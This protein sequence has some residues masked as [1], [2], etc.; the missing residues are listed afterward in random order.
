[1]KNL[2]KILPWIVC[3]A[4]SVLLFL[5]KQDQ[6][7]SRKIYQAE[8]SIS[9]LVSVR[10]KAEIIHAKFIE[11]IEVLQTRRIEH[12]YP[13]TLKR[14][15]ALKYTKEPL[16]PEQTA[17]IKALEIENAALKVENMYLKQDN[18]TLLEINSTFEDELT[19]LRIKYKAISKKKTGLTIKVGLGGFTAGYL[20]GRLTK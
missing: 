13:I 6:N 4:L 8:D 12:I 3:I 7:Q 2:Y 15:E 16:N 14:K 11:K 19:Q 17:Y 9:T 1:M 5:G 18:N 20:M 10:K